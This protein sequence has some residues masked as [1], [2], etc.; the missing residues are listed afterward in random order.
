MDTEL[1]R[2]E[3]L[4]QAEGT[5]EARVAFRRAL[6]RR[7]LGC[8]LRVGDIVLVQE[9]NRTRSMA[10]LTSPYVAQ[11][12]L[13]DVSQEGV[14]VEELAEGEVVYEGRTIFVN[15]RL[16]DAPNPKT[17][18]NIGRGIDWW[19]SVLKSGGDGWTMWIQPNDDQITVLEPS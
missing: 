5:A 12:I 2:L 4:Y 11:V 10:Y 9:R 13:I 14:R 7:G 18:R 16:L 19:V 17:D 15:V 3:R 1:R 6:M 8:G